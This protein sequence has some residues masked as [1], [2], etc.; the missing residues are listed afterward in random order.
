MKNTLLS[1]IAFLALMGPAAL[2]QSTPGSETTTVAPAPAAP[3]SPYKI[4][5]KLG[6]RSY[7]DSI[8][9]SARTTKNGLQNFKGKQEILAGIKVDA[10]WSLYAQAVQ[11]AKTYEGGDN[12]YWETGD[13]SI[14]IGHP[15]WYDD[16]TTRISGQVRSYYPLS[17][18]SR[19]KQIRQYAYYMYVTSKLGS[20]DLYNEL[21]PRAFSRPTYKTNDQYSSVEDR[22]QLSQNLNSWFRAGVGQFSIWEFDKGRSGNT[23]EIYPYADFIVSKELFIGPRIYFPVA[24]NGFVYDGPTDADLDNTY[25]ELFIKADL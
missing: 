6:L 10:G 14:T 19:I 12:N 20:M 13:P 3:S 15:A 23:I 11:K 9:D 17:E 21:I 18:F 5:P 22:T 25:A 2:A 16:G 1:S 7:N 8:R 24:S 4:K